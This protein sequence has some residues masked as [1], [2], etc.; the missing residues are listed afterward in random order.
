MSVY[1]ETL[2]PA[3]EEPVPQVEI[4]E[5]P[6]PQEEEPPIVEEAPAPP[7]VEE[8]TAPTPKKRG[9]PNKSGCS[10]AKQSSQDKASP[11]ARHS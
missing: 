7:A 9:R 10:S 8:V 3:Q 6:V 1:L 11:T 5:P 4:E 2:V